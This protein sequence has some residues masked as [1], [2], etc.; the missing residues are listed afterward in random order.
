MRLGPSVG[1]QETVA[2]LTDLLLEANGDPDS[3]A[4]RLVSKSLCN[5]EILVGARRRHN[6]KGLREMF[7][8]PPE[9]LDP[10]CDPALVRL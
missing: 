7:N 4:G 10:D 6:R 8:Q 3:K 9:V 5:W 2:H 1:L